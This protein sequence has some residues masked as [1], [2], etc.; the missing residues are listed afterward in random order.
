MLE[1]TLGAGYMETN[2]KRGCTSVA[3]TKGECN[4]CNT[5]VHMIV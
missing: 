3:G 2:A 5:R 4:G 1:M